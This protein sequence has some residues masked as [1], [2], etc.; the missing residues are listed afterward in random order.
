MM[1]FEIPLERMREGR[2]IPS[3]ELVTIYDRKYISV[4][5]LEAWISLLSQLLVSAHTI[6]H[7]Y[8][9][10]LNLR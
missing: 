4:L 9:V 1:H 5:D 2:E 6:E 7:G 3:S 10:R 8:R